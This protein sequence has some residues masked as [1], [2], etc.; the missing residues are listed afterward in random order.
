VKAFKDSGHP[1]KFPSLLGSTPRGLG[2]NS[3]G[4]NNSKLVYFR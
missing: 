4:E 2:V 1:L 3:G